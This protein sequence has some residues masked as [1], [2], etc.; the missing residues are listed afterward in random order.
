[1]LRC[2]PF[3]L[4]LLL[5]YALID[6]GSFTNSDVTL[7]FAGISQPAKPATNNYQPTTS[8]Y[9]LPTPMIL[10]PNAKINLGL[11]ITAKRKDGFHDIVSCM[12]PIGWQDVLEVVELKEAKKKTELTITGIEIPGADKDNLVLRAY[13]LLRKDYNLPPVKVHL[14][15][16]IPTGAGL[17][18]GSADAAYMLKAVSELFQLFLDDFI[19]EDY[20][21]QLGSDCPF[22]VQSKPVLAVER[23]DVFEDIKLDLKGHHLLVVKPPVHVATAVAYAAVVPKAPGISIRE[24]IETKPLSEWRHLLHNDFEDSIFPK[25]PQIKEV[26]EQLYAAGAIYASMSGSGAAVYGIFKEQAALSFPAAYQHWQGM[27]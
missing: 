17:G 26:K 5:R 12:Y 23:G 2:F 24:I 22:F 11:N 8:N 4:C 18:G 7:T 15:K 20:A 6:S 1:M 25:Y 10:F 19:L 16:I 3:I 27:M 21:G 14:H 13:E 9:S